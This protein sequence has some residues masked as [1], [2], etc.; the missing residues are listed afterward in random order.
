MIV[1]IELVPAQEEGLAGVVL[2]AGG[3]GLLPFG[4]E[5]LV[6]GIP[7]LVKLLEVGRGGGELDFV[8][9][10]A[11]QVEGEGVVAEAAGQGIQV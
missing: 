1:R 7:G 11:G 8:Q 6:E 3:V 5:S 10:H 4:Q 2:V 9:V